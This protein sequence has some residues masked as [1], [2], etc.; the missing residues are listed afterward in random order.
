MKTA[1]LF[2]SFLLVLP[3]AGAGTYHVAQGH[4]GA[5]DGN[6]GTSGAPW[7]TIGRA[8]GELEPG[9]TV[10]IHAGTYRE[11]VRPARSG[12]PSGPITYRAAG[13]DEVV[14]TGADI[15][16]GWIPWAPGEGKIWVKKP[17]RHR[18]G[19][20]P[21]D[22]RHRLIGR[23]EQVIV[24]G[25]LLRQVERP[26]DLKGEGAGTFCAR[27]GEEILY[28]RLPGGADPNSR[29]V[30][31]SVRRVCF[32]LGWG[33]EPRHFIHLRGITIRHAS[34]MAQRGALFARGDHWLIEDCM[35]EW[36]N[37]NGI[38]FRGDDITLRRVRSHHNGQMG[39]GGG[40]HRFLLEEVQLDHNNLKGYSKEWEAGGI[41]ITIGRDGIVR[42]C[43]AVANDG[44]GFW[45]DID[46]RDVLVKGCFCK[47]NGGHGIYV[48]ISGGFQ[49][50]NNLCIRNGLD[51][52]WAH[53]G[54]S[55]A[56]SDHCT[57]EGNTCLLNPTGISIR[58]QGPRTFRGAR[59]ENVTYHVH[60]V[61]IR[62]NICALNSR[63]QF[64]L[65]WDNAFFGP[66]PSEKGVARGTPYDPG[67]CNI[68]LDHN[69]YWME[70]GQRLALWGVPWRPGHRKYGDLAS[71]Q[72]ER[73]QDAGSILADPLF[74]D[75]AAGNWN[76]K[77]GSP[78]VQLKAGH[79]DLPLK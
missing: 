64:G 52:K 23:C 69:L 50:R 68:R 43:R 39:M 7:K 40:G 19:V 35:V 71:W 16:T 9:D 62:R 30:E 28:V 57:I 6:P 65:W 66:H 27:P 3:T 78:A 53:G 34:N 72:G 26:G 77:P 13:K 48:E 1:V 59:R 51:D 76:L 49:I 15:I 70:A 18:F 44:V 61:T 24:D 29:V 56:E 32:G 10:L 41:K 45:F 73:G 79:R 4:P 46:V 8:A 33:G 55:I 21:D 5:S 31:A 47:D 67:Q 37:G 38:T 74:L 22:E 58:E 12:T 60:D 36:T 25:K 17:W 63:Y 2:S 11:Q 42:R 20:H 54:I 75:P 14:I